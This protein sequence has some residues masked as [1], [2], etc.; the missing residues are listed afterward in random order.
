M[1]FI[2]TILPLLFFSMSKQVAALCFDLS[3]PF[4]NPSFNQSDCQLIPF[5]MNR[6]AH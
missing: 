4:D 2:N 6:S 5:L 3:C 1:V